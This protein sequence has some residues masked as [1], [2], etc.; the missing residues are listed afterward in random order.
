MHKDFDDNVAV[1][2]KEKKDNNGEKK[3]DNGV[4]NLL[5]GLF[6]VKPKDNKFGY[7]RDGEKHMKFRNKEM[8]ILILL[9]KT[10]TDRTAVVKSGFTVCGKYLCW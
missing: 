8:K 4:D 6:V 7:L 1:N 10:E 2:I 3:D 5:V 9:C